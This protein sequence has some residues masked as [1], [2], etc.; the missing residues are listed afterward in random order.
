MSALL[1]HGTLAAYLYHITKLT[2]Y[3]GLLCRCTHRAVCCRQLVYV[4]CQE[5]EYH[6]VFLKKRPSPFI[7]FSC[8]RFQALVAEAIAEVNS[9]R[10]IPLRSSPAY[11]RHPKTK[12]VAHTGG[13][14]HSNPYFCFL[15]RACQ[16]YQR[17]YGSAVEE[18]EGK[19]EKLTSWWISSVVCWG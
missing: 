18:P 13:V 14:C 9:M 10:T 11:P 15:S 7:P 17:C 8:E 3:Y 19:E 2:Y 4:A 12:L 1:L 6:W 5:T 16:V